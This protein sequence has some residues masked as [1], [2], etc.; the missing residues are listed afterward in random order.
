MRFLKHII[1]SGLIL[2]IISSLSLN[3][4]GTDTSIGPQQAIQGA[5]GTGLSFGGNTTETKNLFYAIGAFWFFYLDGASNDF[6]VHYVTSSNGYVWQA[7][8]DTGYHASH[9]TV[10]T[11]GTKVFLIT[12]SQGSNK[13][14]FRMGT[15]NYISGVASINWGA[16]DGSP[17]VIF[18]GASNFNLKME[19]NQNNQVFLIY[20]PSANTTLWA[21]RSSGTD[22]STWTEKTLLYSRIANGLNTCCFYIISLPNKQIYVAWLSL[23]D[24]EV[25]GKLWNNGWGTNEAV[26]CFDLSNPCTA[27]GQSYNELE[28]FNTGL[29]NNIYAYFRD[30]N[31]N[32]LFAFRVYSTS[33]W[34]QAVTVT[35]INTHIFSMS[36]DVLNNAIYMFQFDPVTITVSLFKTSP[37]QAS[38]LIS[39]GVL[40][41]MVFNNG[42]NEWTSMY[43]SVLITSATGT[44]NS[45]IVFAWD[46]SSVHYVESGLLIIDPTSPPPTGPIVTSNPPSVQAPSP[47]V[48][49]QAVV[50]ALPPP[51]SL[52]LILLTIADFLF[53][54]PPVLYYK[55]IKQHKSFWDF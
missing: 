41:S 2:L 12:D 5:I 30:I 9:F 20:K 35:G 1:Q 37:N 19:I 21:I 39:Q 28:I 26:A 29:D 40:M 47:G 45:Y 7:T 4:H 22:Y 24:G 15:L 52:P 14:F 10:V 3:I 23:T 46:A 53:T 25:F 49:T 44:Q 38:D 17:V 42:P 43:K 32:M 50:A 54:I 55:R 27:G 33:S 13:I 11:N 31:N 8:H 34:G 36:Y 18:S 6:S 51:P 16:Y 48:L